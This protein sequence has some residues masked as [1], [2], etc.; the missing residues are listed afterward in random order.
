MTLRYED[1]TPVGLD[2]S[3]CNDGNPN[4]EVW[5]AAPVVKPKDEGE[6]KPARAK[7]D[8][9]PNRRLSRATEM[10]VIRLYRDGLKSS[11]AVAQELGIQPATVFKVLKRNGIETRS[12]AE[13]MALSRSRRG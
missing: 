10:Q 11:K 3:V 13:G 6:P 1:R 2:W 9:P 5:K 8:N 7:S 12:R 4:P